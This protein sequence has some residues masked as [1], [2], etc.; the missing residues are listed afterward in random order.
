MTEEEKRSEFLQDLKGFYEERG[1]EFTA[2]IAVEDGLDNP[3]DYARYCRPL[4]WPHAEKSG[5]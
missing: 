3:D 1:E 2:E 4:V 5:E